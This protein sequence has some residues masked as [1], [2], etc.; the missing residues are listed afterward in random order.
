MPREAMI[1]PM[2]ITAEELADRLLALPPQPR[3]K[4]K[5]KPASSGKRAPVRMVAKSR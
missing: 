1:P 2:D 3:K 5:R 4:S